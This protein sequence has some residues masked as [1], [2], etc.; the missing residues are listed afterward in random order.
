MNNRFGSL[1]QIEKHWFV[2]AALALIGLVVYGRHL[3][4]GVTPSNVIFSLF[5]LDVYWYGFLIM[6]GIAL[7]AYVAS[8]LARERSLAALA[9]TVPTELR[10]QP[11]ATL[12]WPIELKQHLATVKITTLGDLL[13]RYGWQPQSL[14]LRPA[15]LDEL[16]HVLDEAEAIQPEWLDNPP[17]YNWWPEHAWNGLLW[18][19]IL[20]IIG[21]RLYHV[22]TPSPSMAA[23]GIETAADYF[24]QPLQLINLRRGG[25]G[26]Y[27][28]L[29]GGALGIL[30]Y[31]R[32]RRLP[33][34]G[35]LDL[36]A[37]GAALGQVI[38]RWGNF[39]NQELYG[40]PTQV[41]WALYIDFEHRLDAYIEFERFHPAFL[42]ESLWSLG[43]FLLLYWLAKRR[44]NALRQGELFAL[45]M[46]AYAIGRVLLELVRLD[47]RTMQLGSI[48]LGLPVAT[49]VSLLVALAMGIWMG[50]RRLRAKSA[51]NGASG[52]Q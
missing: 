52:S 2:L 3:A 35:W 1:R 15:E 30:I 24:R 47:S 26:I 10:E 7:G 11:I 4:T 17:W 48:D 13:L 32:Q 40:R 9:A 31:T 23:F 37:V 42:Y 27:G 36:A 18:T 46:S 39:L 6:G 14:G 21:A 34:L 25:L 22:L 5:G 29:A 50:L 41:P 28:G 19:L 12:D 8:R 51:V 33:A 20:A 45:Y 16:R 43:T 44:T 49:V 38:G